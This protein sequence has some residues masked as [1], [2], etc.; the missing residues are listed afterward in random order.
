MFCDGR[1][2]ATGN[3]DEIAVMRSAED[4]TV[5]IFDC[6]TGSVQSL[7]TMFYSED[8]CFYSVLYLKTHDKSLYQSLVFLSIQF[9]K[10]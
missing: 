9:L 1:F 4:L 7:Q 6:L 10:F 2:V 3:A 5:G 8:C